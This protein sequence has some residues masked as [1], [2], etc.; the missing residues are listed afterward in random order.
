MRSESLRVKGM[1]EEAGARG[2]MVEEEGGKPLVLQESGRGEGA[3]GGGG[4]MEEEKEA[5]GGE[6]IE[7]EKALLSGDS[8]GA[9]EAASRPIRE[10]F[11][12]TFAAAAGAGAWAGAK[13]S[14]SC[15]ARDR[16][17]TEGGGETNG[18]LGGE[19]G[20]KV[21]MNAASSSSSSDGSDMGA[22][23]RNA[24]ARGRLKTK[25]HS[26]SI[27][28]ACAGAQEGHHGKPIET[29]APTAPSNV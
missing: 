20:R 15:S 17:T 1:D 10:G 14:S 5:G 12:P 8:V 28:A 23:F 19:G 13:S 27:C 6:G 16:R 2:S 24:G 26:Q 3:E 4:G 7:E 9:M 21:E 29:A 18:C 11:Q 22:Q 25:L